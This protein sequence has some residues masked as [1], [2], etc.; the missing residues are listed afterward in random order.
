M[1]QPSW[2]EG[3]VVDVGYTHGY[4]RELAPSTLGFVMLLAGLEAPET[5]RPFGYYELGCGNGLSTVL[6]A[7]THPHG[8]FVGVDFNPTHIHNAQ[9]LA[10]ACGVGNVQ[11]LEKSFAELLEA[12]LP[13]AD[14]IALHGVWTWI[15]DEHRR[16]LVEFIR[17]RLKPGGIVYVSYNCLPGLSQ[18]A[19]LQ[20]LLI[21]HGAAA[22]GGSFERLRGALDFAVR[23]ERAGAAFFRV[24]PLAKGRL[25]SIAGQDPRYLAHEYFNA[26]WSL[27]Y[28][29][30][31]ARDLGGAKLA[32]AG[33]ADYLDNFNQFVLT[34]EMAKLIAGIGDRVAVETLKDYARN[35]VFR[36][37]VYTRGAPKADPRQLDGLLGRSRFALA[38]PRP[39]CKFAATTPAGE[40]ALEEHAYAP[41][42][43]ALARGP[44]TFDE[45]GQAAETR[46]LDR[47]R[48][49]QAVFGMAALG[50]VF[51][52][53][54]AEGEEARRAAARK[55]NQAALRDAA[56]GSPGN[57]LA[58]P[59]LGAGVALSFMDR[60]FLD[61]RGDEAAAVDRAEQA[62]AA[63]GQKL[64][65]DGKALESAEA[66]RAAVGE[67]ARFFH[68]ET[69][70]FYRQLGAV[71]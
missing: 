18:V 62:L 42:L 66:I 59:V 9:R 27:F 67:K 39:V 16:Q 30:E 41:V 40:V 36:R 64:I 56:P 23:L 44:M 69:L 70:P 26:N 22:A 45:L 48:L 32:F 21:E 71:D 51:P 46:Q 25:D 61:A 63:S 49:R 10:G 68:R 11:F 24:N 65:K 28:H 35:Q 8:R 19:P 14:I 52:A 12:G 37:D 60:A 3:Y 20:R 50:N 55:F 57:I 53:L 17:R 2:A 58:S 4:Y 43:D 5:G 34:P 1:T 31:V 47:S 33:S 6:H 29:A 13:D 7:A 54:P 38:R 15:A